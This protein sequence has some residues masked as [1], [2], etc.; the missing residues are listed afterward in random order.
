VPSSRTVPDRYDDIAPTYDVTRGGGARASAAAAAV[1]ALL[2]PAATVLDVGGGT[3]SVAACLRT[4][5]HRVACLDGS[6]GMLELARDRLPGAVVRSRVEAL[7]VRDRSVDAACAVWLLHLLDD[8]APVIAEIARVLRPGGTFV[9]TVD[10][11]AGDDVG[12]DL[13]ELLRPARADAGPATDRGTDVAALA[14]EV[15]LLAVG[16]GSFAG[17][18]QGRTPRGV[19]GELMS[20][21]G[22]RSLPEVE[23]RRVADGI[24]ALPDPDRPRADPVHR[25]VSFRRTRAG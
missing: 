15:G 25:L 18:G 16:A 12:S 13:D 4:Y 17:H 22:V 11:A 14:A 20:Y 2:P 9:A 3:G 7:P 6:A 23:R 8:A 21:R 10:K 19:L 24:A 5:G 1:A